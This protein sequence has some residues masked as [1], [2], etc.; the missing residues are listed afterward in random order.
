MQE[1]VE[2]IFEMMKKCSA[3]F[4]VEQ[5]C[6]VEHACVRTETG[7]GGSNKDQKDLAGV[8]V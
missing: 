3:G 8:H 6:T 4:V 2:K 7:L 5:C 1:L